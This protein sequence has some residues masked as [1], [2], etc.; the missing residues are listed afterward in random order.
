MTPR[1]RGRHLR[2]TVTALT[3]LSMLAFAVVD[4]LVTD[5]TRRTAWAAS[6]DNDVEWNGLFHDQGPL[7]ASTAEPTCSTPVEVTLR[8]YKGDITSA[9]VKYF[10]EADSAHHWL[11]MTWRRNDATG[12][13]DLWTAT[14]PAS[15]ST[16]YYRFQI[17]D[18]ADTDWYNAGGPTDDEP[19]AL[20]FSVVPGFATPDWAKNSVLYQIFPDRFANGDPSNDVRTGEYSYFGA[21]T[22]SKEWGASV[23]PTP[24]A[25]NSSVFFGGDL[26]GVRDKLGYLKNTLG[27]DA[28]W[29][30]PIFTSPT[31]HKYDIQDYENVDPHLG[32]DSALRAL[33]AD[34]H[35]TSNGPA[36]KVILDGVFNHSGSWAKW[37]DRGNVWPDVT[38]A[39]ESQSSPYAGWYTFVDWPDQYASFFDAT[40]SMPKFDYGA[41]GSAVRQALY[42]STSSVA[43]TWIREYGI[44]GW[45]LD[46]PQYADAGGGNGSNATNHQIWKEFRTAVKGAKPDAFVFGEHWGNARPWTTGGE[47]DAASNFNGFTQPVSQWITGRDYH[48]NPASISTSEFDAWLRGT[49][50]DYPRQ[51]Q[52]VMS[53]HLSNH[54][55]PRFATRAGGDI[56]KTYLAHIFQMTYVG[57]PTIYYGDEYGMQGGADPDNRRTFDWSQGTTANE[58]VALV[59]KLISIRRQYSALRT[60]SFLTLGVDD[61]AGLYAF[62]RMDADHRIAVLLN[63]DTTA[64]SSRIPVY[65]L[66][67]PDGTTMTDAISGR[68]YQVSDGHVE[69]TVDGHYGAILV[70]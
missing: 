4:G 51:A 37:F 16:K 50:A 13:F 66:S 47:W 62:G 14:I 55:I 19:S 8:T 10:D 6:N 65:Q 26:Q 42:G 5:A 38:G 25:V 63:N 35:S 60:G 27:I 20:D 44:D 67:V 49:R 9:N 61:G 45:R 1:S 15:C 32:G 12:R 11:P 7:Y 59:K 64:H 46:A 57:I 54:D 28:I 22:Q 3:V 40:P 69:V 48:D 17:N 58:S 56:W 70:D 52:L 30:N 43:Q 34:M 23:T 21:P 31:N 24:P 18:G 41:S 39:Y 53:N 33:I 68:T 2:R 36:G 29:L